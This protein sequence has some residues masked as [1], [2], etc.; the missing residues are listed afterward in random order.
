MECSLEYGI[1]IQDQ[2]VFPF[3]L[4]RIL[5]LATYIW[6]YSKQPFVME[7]NVELPALDKSEVRNRETINVTIFYYDDY[8]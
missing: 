2:N 4:H 7:F 5:D 6:K 1:L 3:S 8:I